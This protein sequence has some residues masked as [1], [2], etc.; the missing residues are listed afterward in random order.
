MEASETVMV[1]FR[2]SNS[3]RKYDAGNLSTDLE[4][5]NHALKRL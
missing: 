2:V 1:T 3:I 5:E 4:V